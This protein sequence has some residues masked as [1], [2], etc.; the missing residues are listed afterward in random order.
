[1]RTK[2]WMACKHTQFAELILFFFILSFSLFLLTHSPKSMNQTMMN[3]RKHVQCNVSNPKFLV[4]F[5]R[6]VRKICLFVRLQQND[7]IRVSLMGHRIIFALHLHIYA[8]R[9]TM[10]IDDKKNQI[11]NESK[12]VTRFS[13]NVFSLL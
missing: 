4:Y 1:M 11:L 13:K 8:T 10:S 5:N 12:L 9:M 3:K 6:N 7:L 2:I